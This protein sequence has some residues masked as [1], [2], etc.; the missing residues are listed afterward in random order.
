MSKESGVRTAEFHGK[1]CEKVFIDETGVVRLFVE[2]AVNGTADLGLGSGM[3]GTGWTITEVEELVDSTVVIEWFVA[4][5]AKHKLVFSIQN[6]S[7]LDGNLLVGTQNIDIQESSWLNGSIV[8]D[9]DTRIASLTDILVDN[10]FKRLVEII[11]ERSGSRSRRAKLFSFA[12][13]A[14]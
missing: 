14:S 12:I 8:D 6:R 7:T 5:R 1:L 13:K 3:I 2:Y 4:G 9:L 10:Y 11:F